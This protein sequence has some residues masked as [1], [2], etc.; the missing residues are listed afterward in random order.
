M[1]NNAKNQVRDTYWNE[2]ENS[3]FIYHRLNILKFKLLL[4]QLKL[5]SI[6]TNYKQI[7]LKGGNSV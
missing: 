5:K 4:E 3:I 6:S 7:G 1:K 2:K